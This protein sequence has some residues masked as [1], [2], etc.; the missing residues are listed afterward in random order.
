[1]IFVRSQYT[2]RDCG[3]SVVERQISE[4]EVGDSKPTSPV[5]WP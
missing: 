3:G 2:A 4:R 1:M 5:L